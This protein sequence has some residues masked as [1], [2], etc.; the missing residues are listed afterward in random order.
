MT[1]EIGLV[2][3]IIGI[4]MLLFSIDKIAPDVIALGVIVV[5]VLSGL[6]PLERALAGIGSEAFILILGLLVM[7]AGLE[8]TGVV[9][10]AG[11]WIVRKAGHD[12][13][14]FFLFILLAAAGLSALMSNTGAT[15]F[16]LPIVIGMARNMKIS[17][18][19]LLMPLAFASILA[20]SV[21]LIATTTNIVVSGVMEEEGLLPLGMFELTPIG[22]VILIL[23]IVYL[24]TIGKKLIP[25]RPYEEPF[26]AEAS[27]RNYLTDCPLLATIKYNV[28]NKKDNSISK[29]V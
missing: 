19:K 4:T 21:T 2:L 26:S 3:G 25:D 16:F 5:L 27:I 18:S 20:S 14:R 12:T 22:L 1:L 11:D 6:L 8:K 24:L 13:N 28:R 17:R 23:G 15:A 7:T 29:M 9:D 10:M